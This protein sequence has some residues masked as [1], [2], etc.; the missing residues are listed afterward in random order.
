MLPAEDWHTNTKI[1]D[2]YANKINSMLHLLHY[3]QKEHDIPNDANHCPSRITEI[4]RNSGER[5]KKKV[6]QCS[7]INDDEKFKLMLI[8]LIDKF[9]S[10]LKS[11]FKPLK[12]SLVYMVFSK[13][14]IFKLC[15]NNSYIFS[16]TFSKH[17]E[18]EYR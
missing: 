3:I 10:E 12:I 16:W 18:K 7:S 14:V 2:P 9:F 15:Q 11:R 13:G 4:F 6:F 1:S 17:V 5:E 8:T